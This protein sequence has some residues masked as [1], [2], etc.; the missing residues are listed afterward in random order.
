MD[1]ADSALVT[2]IAC[3][4]QLAE[5]WLEVLAAGHLVILLAHSL[6]LWDGLFTEHIQFPVYKY[7]RYLSH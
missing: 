2:V 5:L 6:H 3:I 1:Q 7:D 4:L